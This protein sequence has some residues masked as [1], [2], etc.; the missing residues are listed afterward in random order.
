MASRKKIILISIT[1]MI[2]SLF[3]GCSNNTMDKI[4]DDNNKI[5]NIYDSFS[6]DKSVEKI[7]SGTYKG[8]LKLSGSMTIWTYDS[9][10]DFDLQVPYTLSVKSGKAKIVLVSPDNTVVNLVENTDKSTV[11][12]KTSLTVPIKK[13]KNRI[14]VVGY[15]KADINLELQI[16]KGTFN[17][18]E[19]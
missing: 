13:G 14:R 5:A 10:E 2:I 11:E 19:L 16:D 18:V 17:K 12:G 7:E 3:I 8:N 1:V 4:Y 15:K 6:L 9:S